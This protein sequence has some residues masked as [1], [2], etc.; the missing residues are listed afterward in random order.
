MRQSSYGLYIFGL[1][2]KQ[3]SAHTSLRHISLDGSNLTSLIEIASMSLPKKC[4]ERPPCACILQHACVVFLLFTI[5]QNINKKIMQ[6][7]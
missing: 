2:S 6:V 1:L 4:R 7:L 3:H 5:S